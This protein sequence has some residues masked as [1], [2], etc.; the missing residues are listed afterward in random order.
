MLPCWP[1]WHYAVNHRL[2]LTG[3]RPVVYICLRYNKLYFT[4]SVA[5]ISVTRAV[6][7]TITSW[8]CFNVLWFV[9]WHSNDHVYT[10]CSPL[11][12]SLS[13][14][15]LDK[16][17]LYW[18]LFTLLAYGLSTLILSCVLCIL[19]SGRQPCQFWQMSFKMPSGVESWIEQNSQVSSCGC[20]ELSI[21]SWC[22]SEQSLCTL[23]R[24]VETKFCGWKSRSYVHVGW[25][26]WHLQSVAG[27]LI[28][29]CSVDAWVIFS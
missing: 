20:S 4:F 23:P 29:A 10:T 12:Y 25:P 27:R 17:H 26:V 18:P 14:F 13:F 9:W 28:S 24:G 8:S 15:L 1:P 21:A 19:R 16:D 7:F 5:D 22:H 2:W 11:F 6:N 3:A